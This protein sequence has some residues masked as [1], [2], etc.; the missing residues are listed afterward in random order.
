MPIQ[1]HLQSLARGPRATTIWAAHLLLVG[2][3]AS[4]NASTIPTPQPS[5]MSPSQTGAVSDPQ[6]SSDSRRPPAEVAAA[7]PSAAS[8]RRSSA[9]EREAAVIARRRAREAARAEAA[10][11]SPCRDSRSR[12]CER[13]DNNP[14][15]ANSGG[16]V[17]TFAANGP[18]QSFQIDAGGSTDMRTLPS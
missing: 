1:T 6:P 8:P 14:F 18:T 16:T 5:A 3:C 13:P 4:T 12:D 2:A 15:N 9:D 11:T 7:E 17:V 10:A